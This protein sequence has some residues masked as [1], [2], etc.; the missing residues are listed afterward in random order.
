MDRQIVYPGSIPLDTDILNVQRNTM[1]AL[2]YLAQAILGTSTLVDGLAC[3]PTQPASMS[4]SVGPGCLT[5]LGCAD[6]T[7]FGSLPAMPTSQLVRIGTNLNSTTFALTAPAASGQSLTY[8]IQGSLLEADTTPLV[9]PYYNAANPGQPYSGPENSATAQ[10]TQRRQSVQLMLKAGVAVTS[11]TPTIPAVDAG[12]VGLYAMTVTFAQTS[13]LASDIVK[14]PAAPFI[15]WK[16]PQ[17]SPGT[18][19]LAV[20]QPASQ[21][22]WTVPAGVGAIRVRVW[23]GGGAGGSGF[24]TAGGG[25]AGGGYS[26][27]FYPVSPG[28]NFLVGVGNGGVGAGSGGGTSSFGNLAVATGGASGGNGNAGVAGSGSTLSGTGSGLGL[29]LAGGTGGDAFSAGGTWLSGAGGGTHAG[30]GGV[31]VGGTA[32]ASVAGRSAAG[33]GGGGS[34]GVGNGVG[35]QGGP[36]LVLVEW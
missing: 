9:L 5:Q 22:L 6:T 24:G 20:F 14:I 28:Q 12:W 1:V 17:L 27:G 32:N 25:G 23:G 18:H 31:T 19:N 29:C 16:L 11:G 36:G 13:I 8:L 2:G 21:G 34:G 33:P 10:D 4:V 30:T 7:P 15:T 26:E 3:L 35:G